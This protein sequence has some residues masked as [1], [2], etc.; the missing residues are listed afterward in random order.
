MPLLPPPD[1]H[2]D[3]RMSSINSTTTG[4]RA[5]TSLRFM[6]VSL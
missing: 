5:I 1:E 4:S 3:A 6:V 2:D